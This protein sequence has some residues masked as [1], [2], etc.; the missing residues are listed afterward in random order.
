MAENI[1]EAINRLIHEKSP[2]LQQHAH[3]PVDWR[4]WSLEALDKAGKED[5]P[6]LI[7]IG[8]ASC[9][10]C[11]VM[12]RESFEDPETAGIMN[13]NFISIKIDREERPDLDSLYMKAV[14]AMTGRGGWPLTV[15]ATPAGVPFYG[16]TYYPPEDGFGLP[17]F[18]KILLAVSLSYGKNRGRID[19]VTSGIVKILKGPAEARRVELAASL[20]DN[21]LETAKLFFDPEGHGFGA[22]AKFPHAMFLKFLFRY[23]KRTGNTEAVSMIR[24]TLSAMA[25][26]GIYDHLGGGFHRYSV[27]AGWEVPHF[28]KMLYDNA[29]LTEVYSLLFEASGAPLYK[30]AALE[31]SGY[32]MRE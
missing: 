4:P 2:Y 29:L 27:D 26:G 19:A 10:W 21:A 31:T 11:H 30:D 13:D 23:W 9:H 5:K 8:Y 32:L 14:Q 12:E 20:A 17:S 24:K 1:A 16:G 22:E 15:F 28:E 25:L 7:S 6:L 18:K 3:N